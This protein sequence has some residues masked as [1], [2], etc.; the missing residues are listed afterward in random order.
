MAPRAVNRN[1]NEI[2]TELV[3]LRKHFVVQR[4]L[5]A[6][7][8]TPVSRIK[9]DDKR[10][11]SKLRERDC[12]IGRCVQGEIRRPHASLQQ[13]RVL[14]GHRLALW[15]ESQCELRRRLRRRNQFM[16]TL[17]QY[18]PI[19]R[20][21]GSISWLPTGL[22]RCVAPRTSGQRGW[23]RCLAAAIALMGMERAR[24]A[25]TQW[26]LEPAGTSPTGPD[27]PVSA[28]GLQVFPADNW[29][30]TDIST[31]SV[32]PNSPTLIAACGVRNLHPDFGTTFGIPY[33]TIGLGQAAG[34]L[35][36]STTRTKV[37]PVPTRRFRQRHNRRWREQHG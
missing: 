24:E 4:H 13:T 25:A 19:E 6:A 5:I 22:V 8:R 11:P 23:T 18:N 10:S 36:R 1:A 15:I 31:Q 37:I 2:G 30:N 34:A 12:L 32:D 7:Y 3:K 35:S 17:A 21:R 14:I 20:Q 16:Y 29:W 33:V 28:V 26:R 9:R 27:S